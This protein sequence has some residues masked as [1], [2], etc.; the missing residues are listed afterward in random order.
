MV[1]RSEGYRR[2][3]GKEGIA[4][5]V[6]GL[7]FGKVVGTRLETI[8][9]KDENYMLGDFR[10]PSGATIECKSQPIDPIKYPLNFVEVFETTHNDEHSGGFATVADLLEMS[11]DE[12]AAVPVWMPKQRRSVRLGR[13]ERVSVSIC[14]IAGSAATIYVNPLMGGRHVYVYR[15]DELI[16]AVKKA[17]GQGLVR[18]AGNSNEDTFAVK[19]PL[20]GW[21]WSRGDDFVWHWQG[22][23]VETDAVESLREQL[24]RSG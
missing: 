24:A 17:V 2:S 16:T 21:R 11:E 4:L 14:S 10:A 18:G 5:E 19:V 23:G 15:R 3:A 1:T 9:D 6:A 7:F 12:L 13:P 20:A 22:V 8:A